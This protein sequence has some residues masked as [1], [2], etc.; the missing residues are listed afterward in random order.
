MYVFPVV[1]PL[2]VCEMDTCVLLLEPGVVVRMDSSEQPDREWPSVAT[3]TWA[4]PSE[5]EDVQGERPFSKSP[6]WTKP[7]GV[8]GLEQLAAAAGVG[9]AKDREE[10]LKAASKYFE[11]MMSC[12]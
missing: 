9:A 1:R 7:L 11:Y 2:S 4:V 12:S 5:T 6:F 3:W 10:K 8:V